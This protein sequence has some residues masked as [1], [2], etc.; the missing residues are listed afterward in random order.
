MAFGSGK[1]RKSKPEDKPRK[2]FAAAA[3]T[4]LAR[5][6]STAASR[7]WGGGLQYIPPRKPRKILQIPKPKVPQIDTKYHRAHSST[8]KHKQ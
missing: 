1:K 2:T 7:V 8:V 5:H 4:E 6:A 3:K